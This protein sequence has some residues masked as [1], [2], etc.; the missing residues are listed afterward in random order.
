MHTLHDLE[1]LP[2]MSD[3]LFEPEALAQRGLIERRTSG[4][5]SAFIFRLAGQGFV[6]RHFWRGGLI[7]RVLDDSY[8]WLGLSRSRP[9]REWQLLDTLHREGLPVP[10]PAALRVSHR[11]LLYRADLITLQ[12]PR[13]RTL[14]DLLQQGPPAPE[15]W[16]RVGAVIG[17]LHRRGAFHADLNARNILLDDQHAV[18]LID[19]DRGRLLRPAPAWQQRNLERLRRSLEKLSGL[20]SPFHYRPAD[21]AQLL[22]GYA[23]TNPR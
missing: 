7:G 13:T 22:L 1:L 20:L 3:W 11:G 6:L 12:L 10:R 2:Q 14:A 15:L 4:R 19:W 5:R 9:V 21:F 18:Y 16:Q 23:A 8:L 17:R